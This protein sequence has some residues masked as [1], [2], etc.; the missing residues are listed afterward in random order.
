MST[1]VWWPRRNFKKIKK[2]AS[3][4]G[5]ADD[6]GEDANFSVFA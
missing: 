5:R 4:R 2:N 6:V 3:L 1:L